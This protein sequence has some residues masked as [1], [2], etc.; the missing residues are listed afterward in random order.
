MDDEPAASVAMWALCKRDGD[1]RAA[2]APLREA[3]SAPANQRLYSRFACADL[4][5]FR[6]KSHEVN[7]LLAKFR[8]TSQA[9][10]ATGLPCDVTR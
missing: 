2:E 9:R 10:S 5:S 8:E 1:D 6:H 3:A 4:A 7:A